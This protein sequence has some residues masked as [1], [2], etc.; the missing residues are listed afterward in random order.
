MEER[1]VHLRDLGR[2]LDFMRG[3]QRDCI[4]AVLADR[5][6]EAVETNALADW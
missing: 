1:P 4:A 2:L 3:V 6:L 5:R